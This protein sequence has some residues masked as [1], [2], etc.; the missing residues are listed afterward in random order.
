MPAP[1]TKSRQNAAPPVAAVPFTAA[2]HEHV[3]PIFDVTVTPGAAAVN[4]PPIDIPSYGYGRNVLLEVT[5]SVNGALGGGALSADFPFNIFQSI[6]L[7]DVNG[8]PIFGPLDGYA[9]FQANVVG[10]YAAKPDPRLSPW[11]QGSIVGTAFPLR[12]PWE[13]S[14]HDGLG[15]VANQNSAAAY[16]LNL[17]TNPLTTLVTGGAPTAPTLRIRG[18]LEAWSLPNPVDLVGRPQAQSPPAHGT[19][20]FWSFMQRDVGSGAITVPLQRMGNLIRNVVVIARTAAGVRSDTVFPNPARLTW[21]ARTLL[22]ESQNA[23]IQAMFERIPQLVT[24]DAGVF[25]YTF[26]HSSNNA[27]GD[28]QPSLWL[29]TVQSSRIELQGNNTAAGSLQIITNDIAPGE[30]T[31]SERYVETSDTGFHPEVGRTSPAIQ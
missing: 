17:T 9:A 6:S 14:H 25:A 1:A 28:D 12:V 5:S 22:E 10:G 15:A 23:R 8:A 16:R 21:D 19:M 11:Y 30:V 4:I 27:V 31:P 13:I 18:F 29:P 26:N 3:E 24:R 2:A 7:T 20:Q